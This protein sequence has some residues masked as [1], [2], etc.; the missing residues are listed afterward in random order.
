MRRGLNF[1]RTRY[2]RLERSSV[3]TN[4][5]PVKSQRHMKY[6]LNDS[7]GVVYTDLDWGLLKLFDEH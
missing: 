4:D 2:T 6:I 3:V 7:K 1:I 5:S